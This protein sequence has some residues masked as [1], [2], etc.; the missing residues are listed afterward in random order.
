[1]SDFIGGDLI[2]KWIDF[3]LHPDQVETNLFSPDVILACIPSAYHCAG[4][5]P[6]KQ[7][8]C[9]FFLQG[10]AEDEVEILASKLDVE[11]TKLVETFTLA[12]TLKLPS[13]NWLFRTDSLPMN[14]EGKRITL[15]LSMS[16]HFSDEVIVKVNV[17]WDPSEVQ[18]QILSK[19][20]EDHS[21]PEVLVD[22]GSTKVPILPEI[23]SEEGPV[24]NNLDPRSD[25]NTKH[26]PESS[27]SDQLRYLPEGLDKAATQAYDEKDTVIL[28]KEMVFEL[29]DTR[30]SSKD[31]SVATSGKVKPEA[32][33][34]TSQPTNGKAPKKSL[35][36]NS[37][38]EKTKEPI[39]PNHVATALGSSTKKGISAEPK[40]FV[41]KSN[42]QLFSN[43]GSLSRKSSVQ[44]LSKT[45]SSGQKSSAT[46]SPKSTSLSRQSSFTALSS[47][48]L[49]RDNGP[50]VSHPIR[51]TRPTSLSS[52]SHQLRSPD[53]SRRFDL[54]RLKS[55][56]DF[57]QGL[58]S[59]KES[60]RALTR[61]A[62]ASDTG[63]QKLPPRRETARHL[64]TNFTIGAEQPTP[65]TSLKG[66]QTPA[67]SKELRPYLNQGST[68]I[69]L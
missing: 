9:S 41:K 23:D 44:S 51:G 65:P 60:S 19:G 47:R 39:K 63:P 54:Q 68:G 1:M 10:S 67:W 61:S 29:K 24:K 4:A 6:V 57:G 25:I 30:Q 64:V 12:V 40:R 11:E 31:D 45:S 36:F 53:T 66:S 17:E 2:S 35:K 58:D 15:D 34:E 59:S 42:A 38:K 37:A 28:Q 32:S 13:L 55:Q 62:S 43:S 21:K 69:R 26:E 3:K 48:S 46:L 18:L 7:F 27:P 16:F 33:L 56:I 5:E 22:P 52:P 20:D 8:I 14:T 49:T 50:L